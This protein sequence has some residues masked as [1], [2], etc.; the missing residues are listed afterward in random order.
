MRRSLAAVLL[1]CVAAIARDHKPPAGEAAND[2]VSISA[3]VFDAEQLKQT[4]G[5]GFENDY[6]V[7]EITVRPKTA[8]PYEI[9]LDDFILRSEMSADHSGPLL[10]GQI[11]GSG[12]LIVKTDDPDS[13]KRKGGFS[14]GIGGG[15]IGSANN[16]VGETRSA[17]M[18]ED[19]PAGAQL[20][21]LKKKILAEKPIT[22]PVTGLLFFPLSAKEKVKYLN[23]Q[24]NTPAGTLRIRFK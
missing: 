12:M 20:D 9:K 10:A 6:V 4:V 15:M 24:C 17:E 21:V 19:T 18:K 14:A 2:A 16:S 13:G 5:A 8:S 3:I 23:L 22:A 1:L 11:A 7:L